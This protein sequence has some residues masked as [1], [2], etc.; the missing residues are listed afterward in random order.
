MIG[1]RFLEYQPVLFDRFFNPY[2]TKWTNIHYDYN[3]S[4]AFDFKS[5]NEKEPQLAKKRLK[6]ILFS[7]ASKVKRFFFNAFAKKQSDRYEEAYV[8]HLK[9]P[10]I[11]KKDVSVELKDGFLIVSYPKCLTDSEKR[12]CVYNQS[13]FVERIRLPEDVD[14]T[15]VKAKMK[16]GILHVSVPQSKVNKVK[17]QIRVN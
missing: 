15:R 16:N 2:L 4:Y 11:R 1:F 9:L 17:M 10:G 12:A 8:C 3:C 5:K 6:R 7:F 13:A 14:Y